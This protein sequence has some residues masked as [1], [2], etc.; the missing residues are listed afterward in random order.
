MHDTVLYAIT[1][2]GD[3]AL[4][5][6][7]AVALAVALWSQQSGAAALTW[8]GTLLPGLAAITALKLAGHTCEA[9]LAN[10][11]L[12]SPSGHAA[13]ATMVYGSAGVI[14]ARHLGGVARGLAVAVPA[15]VI[16]AVAAT[17]LLL[18]LHSG[19]EVAIGLTIGAISVALFA[20]RY[21]TLPPAA[22]RS[23]RA[24]MLLAGAVLLLVALHGERLHAEELIRTIALGL[25]SQVSVCR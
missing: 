6:P 1:D 17:R 11:S 25:R 4:M 19:L 14:A 2:L 22:F 15:G 7:L 8:L 23:R 24:G 10:P 16:A 21:R 18:G 5:L 12:V 9:A 3:S 13:F 20:Q